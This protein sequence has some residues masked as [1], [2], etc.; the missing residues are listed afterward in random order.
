MKKQSTIYHAPKVPKN[1]PLASDIVLKF[2]LQEINNF[3]VL[4]FIFII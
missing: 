3:S 2:Y 4:N 1:Y